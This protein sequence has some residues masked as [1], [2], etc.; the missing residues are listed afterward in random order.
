LNKAETHIIFKEKRVSAAIAL[1]FRL[2][3]IISVF[4]LKIII[5]SYNRGIG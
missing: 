5:E 4:I 3:Y 1:H 2:A